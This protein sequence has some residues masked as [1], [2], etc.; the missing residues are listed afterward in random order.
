MRFHGFADRVH[1]SRSL[2]PL[3][4]YF[5]DCFAPPGILG[6]IRTDILDNKNNW[7]VN[8]ALQNVTPDQR[9]VSDENYGRKDSPCEAGVKQVFKGGRRKGNV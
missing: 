8:I 2:V 5:Q 1:R 4:E 7:L 9:R 3:G 6:K